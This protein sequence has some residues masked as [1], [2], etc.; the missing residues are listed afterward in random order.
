MIDRLETH[1]LQLSFTL[2]GKRDENLVET[3]LSKWSRV[4]TVVF[5][6]TKFLSCTQLT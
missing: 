5:Q 2:I 1:E 6:N 4:T 3:V